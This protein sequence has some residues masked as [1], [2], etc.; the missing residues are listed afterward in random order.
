MAQRI[1]ILLPKQG[2]RIWSLVQEDSK[3]SGA[4]KPTGHNYWSLQALGTTSCSYRA[5]VLRLLKPMCSEAYRA[6][7]LRLLKPMCPEAYWAYVLRLLKPMCPEAYRAYVLR[8]PKPMCPEAYRAYV[9]KTTEAH[10]PRSLC[11]ATRSHCSPRSPQL[12]KPVQ[13]SED[14]CSQR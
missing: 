7:V 4:T 11:S 13:S 9:L 5:Y 3:Y 2:T 8:L 10:V 1:R 6:Y 14:P 12:I